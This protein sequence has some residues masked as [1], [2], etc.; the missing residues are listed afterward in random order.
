MGKYG[1]FSDFAL[2]GKLTEFLS[3]IST[4]RTSI[5]A[6]DGDYLNTGIDWST[7]GNGITLQPLSKCSDYSPQLFSDRAVEAMKTCENEQTKEMFDKVN[8]LELLLM[9]LSFS[10]TLR[11]KTQSSVN[12]MG[13]RAECKPGTKT[14]PINLIYPGG[15]THCRVPLSEYMKKWRFNGVGN[16]LD[17]CKELEF[18]DGNYLKTLV[19]HCKDEVLIIDNACIYHGFESDASNLARIG[20]SDKLDRM[21]ANFH[22]PGTFVKYFTQSNTDNILQHLRFIMPYLCG[23]EKHIKLTA[24]GK[25][26][27]EKPDDE[28]NTEEKKGD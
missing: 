2:I 11:L 13:I 7:Y 28:A 26:I 25:V 22:I 5:G 14:A 3:C 10:T 27:E 9:P 17:M 1:S 19:F 15:Q 24:N 23:D 18:S 8:S 20:A 4:Q 16:M 12:I 6:I 21:L